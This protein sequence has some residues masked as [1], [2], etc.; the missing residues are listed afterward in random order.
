VG[1][2]ADAFDLQFTTPTGDEVNDVFVVLV[3]NNPYV[4]GPSLSSSQRPSLTTG[5]LGV[6]AARARTGGDAV[7][8]LAEATLHLNRGGRGL[9]QFQT[10]VFEVRSESGSVYAGV[11]GEALQLPTPL[12][13]RIHPQGLTMLVP[14]DKWAGPAPSKARA[15]N[16]RALLDVARGRPTR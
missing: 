11:D 4:V 5:K 8:V 7:S 9:I 2:S 10:D 3:S 14:K 13:F 12:E 6:T 1:R 15:M 16:V